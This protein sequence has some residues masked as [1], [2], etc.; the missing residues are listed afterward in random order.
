MRHVA[1]DVLVAGSGVAG[2]ACAFAARDMGLNVI[3][4]EKSDRI[5]GTTAWSGGEIWVPC[6]SQ[7]AEAGSYTAGCGIRAADLCPLGKLQV[8]G[9]CG[10]QQAEAGCCTTSCG[11][12]RR[13]RA[14]T[15]A[16]AVRCL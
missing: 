16:E 4:V 1:C 13:A 15:G 6:N 14:D 12:A 5:G 11:A 2:L 3:V 9:R 8:W 7:Q 10:R